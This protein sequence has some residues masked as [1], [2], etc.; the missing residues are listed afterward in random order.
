MLSDPINAAD[1][2]DA[3][4]DRPSDLPSSHSP[5]P[6]LPLHPGAGV[7][8]LNFRASRKRILT[9][10]L[11]DPV[12]RNIEAIIALHSQ[13]VQHIPTHQRLLEEI[14][15]FFGRSS[16][17]Y[18]L[19]VA[20]SIWI[21][22]DLIN[23]TGVLPFKLP[24]FIWADYGLDAAALLISTGVLMRQSRQ[25]SF[26]EQRTQLMLQI[27]LLS[28]QKIAKIIALLEELRTDLPNV[29]DRHDPEAE[30]MQEA[31]DPIAVLE[32]LQNNLAKELSP[33]K[34]NPISEV[35]PQKTESI[36]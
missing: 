31:A 7:A 27:N 4:D 25:E 24:P 6:D 20:L 13:E 16:F 12:T 28:E 23:Q 9:A 5:P 15:A 22:A 17:L 29:I 33:S 34:A 26:A 36:S 1:A 18:G 11:P 19:L 32:T 10:S 8:E 3:K 35:L 21:L 2:V 14:A 30:I